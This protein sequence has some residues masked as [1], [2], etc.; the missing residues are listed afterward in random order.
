MARAKKMTISRPRVTVEASAKQDI[1]H[2]EH[3]PGAPRD[4]AQC[5]G[6]AV[7][8]GPQLGERRLRHLE[9][10]E[11]HRHRV[12][13]GGEVVGQVGGVELPHRVRAPCKLEVA[14]DSVRRVLDDHRHVEGPRKPRVD[15]G[16]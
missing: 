10:G 15:V 3:V 5:L 13:A 6:V 12:D 9:V 16:E 11:Q 7:V 8:L 2:P 14:R 1:P 4:V